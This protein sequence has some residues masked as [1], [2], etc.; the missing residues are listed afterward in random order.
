MLHFVVVIWASGRV[1]PGRTERLVGG[2]TPIL[3]GRRPPG[4]PEP[5]GF[6]VFP[7]N[8]GKDCPGLWELACQ[9]PASAGL[10][11]PPHDSPE[12]MMGR[13]ATG[14]VCGPAE[15]WLNDNPSRPLGPNSAPSQCCS[16]PSNR[17]HVPT[18]SSSCHLTGRKVLGTLAISHE[19]VTKATSMYFVPDWWAGA[20][21]LLDVLGTWGKI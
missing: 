15:P 7:S 5:L 9:P 1:R 19:A 17:N 11:H 6:W 13:T 21:D 2:G 14:P 12:T 16:N 20:E 10:P 4:P 3:G 18:S 8:P